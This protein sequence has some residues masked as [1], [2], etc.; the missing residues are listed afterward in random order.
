MAEAGGCRSSFSRAPA[1]LWMPRE[2]RAISIGFFRGW[3]RLRVSAGQA[4]KRELPD[5]ATVEN[6]RIYARSLSTFW[7]GR[8]I[9]RRGLRTPAAQRPTPPQGVGWAWRGG[10]EWVRRRVSPCLGNDYSSISITSVSNWFA[11]GA[12]LASLALF[13]SS[14]SVR[15][16]SSRSCS[17][18]I[19]R[20]S[21]VPADA[22][23]IP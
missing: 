7:P 8:K 18:V 12:T 11:S 21:C 22:S 2:T 10:V 17:R 23:R 13:A 5:V 20:R 9:C 16:I 19:S 15:F 3:M 1:C 4:G 6:C 14:A